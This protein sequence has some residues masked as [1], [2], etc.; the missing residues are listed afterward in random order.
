MLSMP[1]V[2][3]VFS[4]SHQL[5]DA[6]LVCIDVRRSDYGVHY[7]F[8]VLDGGGD[9]GSPFRHWA[10]TKYDWMFQEASSMT[11][12]GMTKAMEAFSFTRIA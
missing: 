2:G 6:I 7:D 12:F 8:F 10:D 11:A 4:T 3:Q 5:S 9:A 1:R